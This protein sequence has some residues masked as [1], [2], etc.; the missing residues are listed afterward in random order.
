MGIPK[1]KTNDTSSKQKQD[2]GKAD[3]RRVI[4]FVQSADPLKP[5]EKRWLLATTRLSVIDTRHGH[6]VRGGIRVGVGPGVCVGSGIRV[7][8]GVTVGGGAG[9]GVPDALG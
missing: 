2:I 4:D 1:S 8:V 7:G 9:V 3:V 5:S 6:S